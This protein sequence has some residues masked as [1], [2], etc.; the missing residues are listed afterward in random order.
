VL[1]RLRNQLNAFIEL[2]KGQILC[3][4][5]EDC[6]LSVRFDEDSPVQLSA[7]GA[8]DLSTETVF[9][10]NASKFASR[11]KRA[12]HVIVELP[13]YQDGN[14]TWEFNVEGFKPI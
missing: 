5:Y 6:V 3:R 1:R 7:V 10:R 12:K 9:F 4:S 2:D 14:R 13:M 11:L 8:A